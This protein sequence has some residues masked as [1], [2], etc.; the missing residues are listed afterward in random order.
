MG[1]CE[2]LRHKAEYIATP[3]TIIFLE[4]LILKCLRKK[5]LTHAN[6][7]VL[8]YH[9]HEISQFINGLFFYLSC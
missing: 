1:W 8:F 4:H 3:K 9:V 7:S 5:Q 6:N 2:A